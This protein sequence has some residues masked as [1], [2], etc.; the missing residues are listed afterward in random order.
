MGGLHKLFTTIAGGDPID[1]F[2]FRDQPP[3]YA[4]AD[5]DMIAP[6][7]DYIEA[8]GIDMSVYGSYADQCT[9]DGTV[10]AMPYRSGVN[11]LFYN[12]DEFD[13]A[14]LSYPTGDWTWEDLR[15]AAIQLT[16]GEGADKVY[17]MFFQPWTWLMIFPAMQQGVK[18][19]TDDYVCDLDNDYVREAL[20]NYRNYAVEDQM[21]PT[22]E[23]VK[24]ESMGI[25][26]VF[27]PGKAA[28]T[29]AGEWFPG[30]LKNAEADGRV[31]YDWGLTYLPCDAEE[32]C[33]VGL[34]TKGAV[35][36]NA[37]NP[38]EAFEYLSWMTGA[39]GQMVIAESGSMPAWIT[40]ENRAVLTESMGFDEETASV[41]FDNKVKMTNEVINLSAAYV[42]EILEEEF[43]L[44]LIGSQDV[45][46]T[47]DN[48]VTRIDEAI[49]EL[50]LRAE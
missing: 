8:A 18:I 7:N 26:A 29:V 1:A 47:I 37:A 2:Y 14:G 5:K 44:F 24:A 34:A 22:I 35:N 12:K 28:M 25:S 19:V 21:M 40:D 43:T 9:I 39:E 23:V 36:A 31:T 15:Q 4:Y 27:L 38:A 17:G 3:F 41:F 30:T 32:Y 42:N 48:C 20:T 10:Y 33:S 6:L 45:D 50:G 13:L 49:E 11:Y 46:T 16:H